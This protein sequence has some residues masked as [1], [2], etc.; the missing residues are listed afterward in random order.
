MAP[1]SDVNLGRFGT[2][3][4]RNG[5]GKKDGPA[6]NVKTLTVTGRKRYI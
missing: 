3:I 4:V 2:A 1:V 6:K 5:L